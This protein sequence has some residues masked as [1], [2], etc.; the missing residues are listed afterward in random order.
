MTGMEKAIKFYEKIKLN[1][2]AIDFADMQ[3][4]VLESDY[5]GLTNAF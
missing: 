3:R 4:H 5:R 2:C 1:V